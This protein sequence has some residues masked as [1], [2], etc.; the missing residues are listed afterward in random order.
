MSHH[1]SRL[2]AKERLRAARAR[3]EGRE[4]HVPARKVIVRSPVRILRELASV[5]MHCKVPCESAIEYD[6]CVVLDVRRDVVAFHAQPELLHYT[7]RDGNPRRHFPDVRVE[8]ASGDVEF[9][10]VKP[11]EEADDPET[12]RLH[13]AIAAEYARR[14]ARYR[15]MRESEVRREPRL[16]NA[17]LLRSVRVRRPTRQQVERVHE[18]LARGA[19]P[20]GELQALLGRGAE[21]RAD[22]LALA[23][24][25][26]VDLDWERRPI[27]PDIPVFLPR[28]AELCR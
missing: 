27:G 25:G 15:V 22:L 16:G 14:G 5:K 20:L 17:L 18:A 11:D 26:L 28:R 19:R 6:H 10:E 23:L 8:L 4:L 12:R 1:K 3:A 7:D 24:R 13:A 21:G 9:H 2:P